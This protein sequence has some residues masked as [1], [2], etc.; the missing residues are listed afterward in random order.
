MLLGRE[1]SAFL[2]RRLSGMRARWPN[3]RENVDSFYEAELMRLKGELLLREDGGKEPAETA[4]RGAVRLAR[5]TEARSLELRAATSLARL[6]C[7]SGRTEEAHR[8][9]SPVVDLVNEG[10]DTPDFRDASELLGGL[11]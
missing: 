6:L 4:F 1:K 2:G 10:L 8:E 5:D 11:A 9:L 3:H 7:E